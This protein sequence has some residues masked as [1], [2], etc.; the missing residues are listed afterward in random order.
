[1]KSSIHKNEK[2]KYLEKLDKLTSRLLQD[3]ENQ[4]RLKKQIEKI[5]NSPMWYVYK[6]IKFI[7]FHPIKL[8]KKIIPLSTRKKISQKLSRIII[9]N[10]K[11]KI[12]YNLQQ[13]WKKFSKTQPKKIKHDILIFG[14]ISWDFRFQRPQQLATELSKLDHRVF[15]IEHEFIPQ[16]KD[17]SGFQYIETEKISTNLY[18]I[19]ISSGSKHFIYSDTC[20]LKDAQIMLG[21][22]KK[23]IYEAKIV[24]PLAIIEHPFWFDLA[25]ILSMPL[26]YDCMDNHSGFKETSDIMSVKEKNL[27]ELTKLNISTSDYLLN[28]LQKLGSKNNLLLSNGVNLSDFNT[29]NTKIP[30]DIANIKKPI[31]GYY[32]AIA[33][34]F[35]S[36]LIEKIAINFP[37]ASIVL[38]GEVTNSS[39]NLLAQ[40]HSNIKLLG[41]KKYQ[42]IP[43]YLRNFDICLIPFKLTQL[44]KATN[45]VKIYEYFSQGKA[46]VST[47]LPELKKYKTLLYLSKNHTEFIKNISLAL[48]EKTDKID[49]RK[50]VAKNNQWTSKAKELSKIFDNYFPKVS[51]IILV[52]NGTQM[53]KDSIDSVLK[54]SFY[55]N[56]EVIVVDNASQPDTVRML[57]EYRKNPEIK[58]ILNKENYGFAKGNNIGTRLASGDY[59]V[60]LNNDI[61]ATPGWIERLVYHAQKKLVGLVGPIT[62]SIG[63]EA[64]ILIEYD[65]TNTH[66]FEKIVK[67][68]IARHWGESRELNNLAAFCWICPKHVYKQIGELDERFG[69]G[70]FEDDDYCHRVS[71]AGYKIV[72]TED[73][74]I[75]HFGGMSFKKIVTQEFTDLFESNKNKF[76]DKWHIKWKAHHYRKGV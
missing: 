57:Q 6:S 5:H 22:V 68:Y 31:I 43:L 62:N 19:K 70:L 60:L 44:I 58:L 76:E 2:Y 26:V 9:L 21:S 67:K 30:T 36:K 7:T 37:Q 56:K 40:K 50:E 27:L 25:T 59:I 73:A 65:H 63:N 47:N 54:R 33:N 52:Y 66:K 48:K 64:K 46:V 23:L 11:T 4:Q 69:R 28:N 12:P 45:P 35:D 42:D 53:S 39:I 61:L 32:G 20:T 18:K 1:M 75:H 74:F 3:E 34:W 17:R 41:E 14:L 55:P 8:I 29:K 72:C 51:I 38:I 49:Q 13:E 15:Y 71:Q 24:N 10:K 16:R